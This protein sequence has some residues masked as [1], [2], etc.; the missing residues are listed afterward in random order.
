MENGSPH[1]RYEGFLFPNRLYIDKLYRVAY[2]FQIGSRAVQKFVARQRLEVQISSSG[3]IPVCVWYPF[4]QP[5]ISSQGFE[6]PFL[7]FLHSFRKR[8][9][10]EGFSTHILFIIFSQYIKPPTYRIL[11]ND[12]K[13]Y[14][15]RFVRGNNSLF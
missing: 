12:K 8:I 13:K 15:K 11:N 1:C 6:Y 7:W 4:P 14:R 10:S 9:L 3:S 2:Q 5:G